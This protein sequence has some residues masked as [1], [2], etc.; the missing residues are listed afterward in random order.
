MANDRKWKLVVVSHSH[1]DREWYFPFQS[2][3]ARLVGM[4]DSLLDILSS[5]PDYRHFTLDGQTILL[6]D[7]LEVR[8]DRRD[9]IERL[10][11][12]GRLLSGPWYAPPDE[13][14]AGGE[15]HIRNLLRGIRLSQSLGGAMIVGYEPDAF[16]HITHLPAILRG[17]GIEDAVIWRGLDDCMRK[18][19]FRWRAPDGSEVLTLQMPLGYGYLG[20]LPSEH[21]QLVV[22]LETLRREL[23]P[24]ATTPYLLIMDGNDHVMPDSDLPAALANAGAAMQDVEIVH[25]SLP[26][27]LQAIREHVSKRKRALPVYQG[28]MRSSQRSPILPGV[29]SAR[30]W[31][32]QRNQRSEDLLTHWAEPFSVWEALLRARLGSDWREPPLPLGPLARMPVDARSVWGLLQQA[33]RFLLMNQE[34]DG[35]CGCS[36]DAVHREMA[37]RYDSCQQ[38]GEE[39][40]RMALSTI[41][42]QRRGRGPQVLVFNPLAGRRSDFTVARLPVAANGDH[43]VE[44]VDAGGRRVPCQTLSPPQSRYMEI[45]GVA[46]GS[47]EVGF[48]APDVPGTGYSALRVVYGPARESH[49]PKTA[50]VIENEHFEVAANPVDGTLTLRDKASGRIMTGLNRIVDGG[51]RG[52]EYAYW[53]PATDKVVDRPA[54][55]AAISVVESGPARFTL[56]VKSVYGLPAGLN[57]DRTERSKTTVDCAVTTCASLYPGVRRV[58]FHTEVDNQ[59][60]DHRL[61]VHFP[62]GIQTDTVRAEQHFGVVTRPVSMPQADET[63]VEQPAATQPQKSFVDVSDGEKGVLLANRGLPEYEAIPGPDSVTLALTLLRCVGWLCR[64]D[65]TT[66]QFIAGPPLLETPDAQLIGRHTFEYSLIPHDGDWRNAFTEAHRFA[67]PLM[68]RGTTATGGALPA[69]ASLLDITS[70]SLVI[71]GVKFAE[72]GNGVVVRLYNISDAPIRG[73]VRLD[74]PHDGVALVD[75]NEKPLA[76]LQASKGWVSIRAKR[77]EIVSLL[78]RKRFW[79]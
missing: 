16:G 35:I 42:A 17:F 6:E 59:A 67:R 8:P 69:R 33:W 72:D 27:I 7:Y 63:W 39:V 44:L 76:E 13:F 18:T 15:S 49:A 58:D 47:L 61:R 73:R 28:E 70:P 56:A 48:I 24:R 62:T 29:I 68:A 20:S 19:E 21:D 60:K 38:I 37:T 26:L 1:W 50:R 43:P 9:E 57:D 4:M 55:P 30:M 2:F 11:R 34:H 3:R 75:L 77:N 45:P 14:L 53:Q 54:R 23:E 52:D 46:P 51:D 74:E 66:R 40:T 79:G 32:K 22:R 12:E 41:A 31:I 36:V 10:I 5:N 64:A 71:S 78:F 65:M 25:G